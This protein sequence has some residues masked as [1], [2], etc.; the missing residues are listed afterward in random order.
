LQGVAPSD[1]FLFE[2]F[3]LDRRGGLSRCNGV[4]KNEPI[5]IGSRALDIL[6]VLIERAGEVVSK[7]EIIAAVWPDT[8]VEDSNLTV[9]I[10][11][12]RRVLDRGRSNGSC[13][14]TVPGRGYR[15]AARVTR[16]GADPP[17]AV[18]GNGEDRGAGEPPVSLLPTAAPNRWRAWHKITALFAVFTLFG[19]LTAW[20]WDH[21]WSDSASY[22]P[23][24]SMVVLPFANLG[25]NLDHEHLVDAITR[26]LTTELS[27]IG[28]GF[29]ISSNTAFTYRNRSVDTRQIGRELAV[30]YVVEGG[31]R[32]SGSKVRVTAQL[33]E[34]ETDQLVW[35]E[36]F[37]SDIGDLFALEDDISRRIAIALGIELVGREAAR[38][39]RFPDAFDYI[40]RGIAV[41]NAPK[42]RKTFAE[43][44]S[45]F[46]RALTLDPRAVEAQSR[47]AI[48]LAGRVSANMSDMATADIQ[49][50]GDLAEQAAAAAPRSPLAHMAKAQV[51]EAQNR[52]DEAVHEYET[53]LTLNRNFLPAYFHIGG[54]KL[55]SGSIEETIPFVERAIRLSPSDP[56]IGFWSLAIGR[57]YFMEGRTDQGVTWLEKARGANPAVPTT[58][59]WLASALA[60]DGKAERAATELAEARR[61]SSDDRYSSIASIARLT[62]GSWAP[63]AHAL[64]EITYVAGLRKAGMPEE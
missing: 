52:C 15:L 5:A 30:R 8:V 9:Q 12:L 20:I 32:R 56:D 1:I 62:A 24:F 57:A 39:T 33:I 53:V 4:G 18:G 48:H 54:C 17:P 22:R 34:A 45:L 55:V 43:A 46:D 14:Q 19:S 40:I 28:H 13:I 6:G 44:I 61:L 64:L 16:Y 59:A 63:K 58:R 42:T 36:Q 10:S 49:R 23:R 51:L 27:R 29:V 3:R 31:I 38:P 7:D 37:D 25:G 47:L 35:A 26:D 60:L 2:D 11:A 21:R 41:M 50:A